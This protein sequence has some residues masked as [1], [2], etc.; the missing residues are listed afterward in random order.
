MSR[1]KRPGHLFPNA[2]DDRRHAYSDTEQ[3]VSEQESSSAYRL[4]YDD[5][6]F[7]LRDEMRPVRFLLELS[8]PE[9]V[10]QEHGVNHSVVIFGSARTTSMENAL[11][12]KQEIEHALSDRPDDSD[13]LAGLAKAD[14]GLRHAGYYEQARKLAGLISDK[15]GCEDCPQLHVITGGGPGVMEAA[16]RGAQEIGAET[17]GLNIVLPHEQHPNPYITPELCFQFHYFALRKMHFMLRARAL[18][19][20]PGGFGTLD[21]LFE[22]LTLIQTGKIQPL[23]VLLFGKDYWERLIDFD[24]LVEEGMISREDLEIFQFVD[25]EERAWE[26]IRGSLEK[27]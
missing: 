2:A 23:P 9:L 12:Q 7:L 13:L 24:L 3:T 21:E 20:F 8:K 14:A 11:L 15:S 6:D 22:T 10:L 18:I 27:D 25:D 17:V 5:I 16:N 26:I 19:A 1:R 4:A